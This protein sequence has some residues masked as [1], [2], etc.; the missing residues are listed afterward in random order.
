M[1]S[2][3]KQLRSLTYTFA[4]LTLVFI[5]KDSLLDWLMPAQTIEITQVPV[6]LDSKPP[7][8][9]EKHDVTMPKKR[10]VK[11]Q[12][13]NK[14]VQKKVEAPLPEKVVAYQSVKKKPPIKVNINKADSA[15]FT[16][17]YGIGPV[18][19]ARVIKFRKMLGGFHSIH[20]LAQT[21]GLPIETYE[22]IKDQL[23]CKGEIKK[24]RANSADFRTLIRH[25]YIDKESVIN[26]LNARKADQLIHDLSSLIAITQMDTSSAKDLIPYL[27]LGSNKVLNLKIDS[28]E[29][30][31]N[32]QA[33][34]S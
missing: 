19:A 1:L 7:L 13:S 27:D 33:G 11:Q 21:Y 12:V 24:M 29:L 28:I 2:E 6:Q 32:N 9:Q 23:V 17:L 5:F 4:F 30:A 3:Q 31:V 22:N 16:R 15:E 25:P 18:L 8:V 34:D 20:Q 14:K 10:Q 26:I